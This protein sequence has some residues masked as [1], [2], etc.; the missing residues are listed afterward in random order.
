MPSRQ[1]AV[2]VVVAGQTR[3]GPRPH[4]VRTLVRSR[5]LLRLV[6]RSIVELGLVRVRVRVRVKG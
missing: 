6:C 2:R 5:T 1:R 4:P 3:G